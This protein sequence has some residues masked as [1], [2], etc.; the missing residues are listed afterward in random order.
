MNS[1]KIVL[2]V[3]SLTKDFLDSTGYKIRLF[4]NLSFTIHENEFT[5]ILAPKG[6][7]KSTLLKILA[8]VETDFEGEIIK[9]DDRIS[10]LIMDSP[11][12]LQWKSVKENIKFTSK[13]S[14]DEEIQKAIDAVGLTGY[15]D[16]SP[17][18]KSYGFR[19]RIELAR[20]LVKNPLIL[21]IDD[22]L[23][24]IDNEKVR[25]ELLLKLRELNKI[26]NHTTFVLA[27]N[28]ITDGIFLADKLLVMSKHPGKIFEKIVV[29]FDDDRD[30]GLPENEKFLEL[31]NFILNKYKETNNQFLPV[32]I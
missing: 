10:A 15:E 30:A 11:T 17:H 1:T 23:S 8:K 27:T 31:R 26:Y 5:V 7:G 2:E 16:F 18:P 24:N 32:N 20:A 3:K 28:N 22:A 9:S 29:D 12:S 13:N 14:S 6:A 4:E 19:F 21:L 25:Y